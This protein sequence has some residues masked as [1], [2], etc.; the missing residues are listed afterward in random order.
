[1]FK[2]IGDKQFHLR[3]ARVVVKILEDKFKIGPLKFGLDPILGLLPIAGDTLSAL[4]SLYIVWVAVIHELPILK[5]VRMLFN[6]LIDYVVG[7]IPILGD[8]LDFLIDSNTKNMD[9]IEEHL[10]QS[11]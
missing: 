10:T 4:A 9:I 5:L 3:N 7:A 1:M 8:I 2:Y 6:V 11:L